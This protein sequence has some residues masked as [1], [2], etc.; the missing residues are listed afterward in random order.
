MFEAAFWFIGLLF[1]VFFGLAALVV[2]VVVVF[3]KRVHKLWEYE[4]DFHDE[5]G[6]YFGEFEIEMSKVGKFAID[7]RLRPGSMRGM[8][9]WRPGS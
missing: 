9:L 1:L 7:T 8:R 3:G 4:A 6:R 5:T 2:L